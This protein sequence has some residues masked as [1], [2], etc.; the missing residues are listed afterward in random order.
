[1]TAIKTLKSN[2]TKFD[3]KTFNLNSLQLKYIKYLTSFL[4]H[5]YT[6]T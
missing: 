3:D 6:S 4:S 5:K 1:M 2:K